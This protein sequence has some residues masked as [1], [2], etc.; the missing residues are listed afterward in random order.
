MLYF[1]AQLY[2]LCFIIMLKVKAIDDIMKHNC[3]CVKNNRQNVQEYKNRII[4][5]K[6][7]NLSRPTVYSRTF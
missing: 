3:S 4:G 5:Q 1:A 7:N 2:L 6:M